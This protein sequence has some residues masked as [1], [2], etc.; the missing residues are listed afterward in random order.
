MSKLTD[1]IERMKSLGEQLDDLEEQAKPLQK[2]Y[3]QLRLELI[4]SEMAEEDIRSLTGGFGRCTLTGDVYVTVKD[5]AAMHKWL[6]ETDNESL[7]VP[8]VNAQSL[9]AFVKEQL[10]K[11]DGDLPGEEVLKVTPFS[12]AVIY[13]K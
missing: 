13:T 8:T 6:N 1:L 7:I 12:R 4:P 5:K 2:E 10:S 3:D 9:K 11:E